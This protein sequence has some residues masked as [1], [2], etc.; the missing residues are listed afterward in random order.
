MKGYFLG[1]CNM[2]W[3]KAPASGHKGKAG[4]S[5]FQV[6]QTSKGFLAQFNKRLKTIKSKSFLITSTHHN[7][8]VLST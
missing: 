6:M 2:L 3:R 4:R 7:T 8:M 1:D 5:A